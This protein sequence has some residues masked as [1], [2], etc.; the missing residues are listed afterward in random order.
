[1]KNLNQR[2]YIAIDLPNR[3][4]AAR[5]VLNEKWLKSNVNI[6][7]GTRQKSVSMKEIAL[8]CSRAARQDG[9]MNSDR[10]E[11]LIKIT[12]INTGY[13]GERRCRWSISNCSINAEVSVLLMIWMVAICALI[14][15]HKEAAPYSLQRTTLVLLLVMNELSWKYPEGT[16]QMANDD[17]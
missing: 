16:P 13:Y 2:H 17:T 12:L 8:G 5:G 14:K 10:K 4:L 9:W 3:S 15:N 1:M 11:Y 7:S 6:H